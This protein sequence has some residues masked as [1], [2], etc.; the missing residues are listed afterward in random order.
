VPEDAGAL[1]AD[2]R[3]AY[4]RRQ[5]GHPASGEPAEVQLIVGKTVERALGRDGAV[6]L[7]DAVKVRW[8]Q[9][10]QEGQ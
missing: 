6:A 3:A 5:W 4:L 1:P 8:G 9:E 10:G 7:M 2:G